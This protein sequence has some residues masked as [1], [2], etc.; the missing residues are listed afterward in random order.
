MDHVVNDDEKLLEL[1]SADFIRIHADIWRKI[2]DSSIDRIIVYCDSLLNDNKMNNGQCKYIFMVGGL[3]QSKYFQ[4]Q[5]I[6]AY[7]DELDVIVPRCG[8]LSIVKGAA[9][10]G[11]IPNFIQS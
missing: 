8:V 9:I 4:Q 1:S 3:S 10:F 6:S 11:C 2:F 5:I 7:G